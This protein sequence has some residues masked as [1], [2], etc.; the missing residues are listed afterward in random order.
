[1]A[2]Y[3]KGRG[4][5]PG[6]TRGEAL[7]TRRGFNTY[8]SLFTSIHAPTGAAICAD[9]GNP[10]LHGMDL[11]NKIICLPGTTGSTSS[12]AVWS[13]L[14]KMGV[15][16]LAMLFSRQIDSLAAGGLIVADIWA[17]RRI[18]TVDRLG[19]EFLE[20][21]QTGD[22]VTIHEDGIVEILGALAPW[23]R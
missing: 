14:A 3:F 1:M 10:D 7:V 8:A 12:G 2:L 19:E 20:T 6:A 17:G 13:R 18:I 22:R 15:A 16:P 5:L 11:A 21:T 4:I 9:S 23:F